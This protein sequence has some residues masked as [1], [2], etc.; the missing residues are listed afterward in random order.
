[1]G[2][3]THTPADLEWANFADDAPWEMDRDN[4]AWDRVAV[5]LRDNARREVPRLIKKRTLPPLGRLV[6]VVTV[7]GWALLPWF[8]KKKR[9]A[10]ATPEQSR[11]YI[12][13]RLRRAIEIGRAH[14]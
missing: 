3:V 10:F 5:V 8:W 9:G 12:S 1:M 13:L 14:V 2:A 7:F 11:A 4:I 6:T